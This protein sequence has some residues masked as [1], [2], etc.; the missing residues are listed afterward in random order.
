[1]VER[2]LSR[3]FRDTHPEAVREIE[4]AVRARPTSR[5]SLLQHALAALFH[6]A[7]AELP[8]ITAPTLVLAGQHDKLLGTEAPREL[9]GAIRRATFEIIEDAGHDVT[10]EQPTT[11]AA[12]VCAFFH[13]PTEKRS[14]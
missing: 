5:V 2:I 14:A 9:A 12:R 8:H 7:R 11:T 4:G 10:L 6:D 3:H 13:A 1:M